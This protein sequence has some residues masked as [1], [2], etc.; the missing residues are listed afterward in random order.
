MDMVYTILDKHILA[1]FL[2]LEVLPAIFNIDLF[3][4]YR[5]QVEEDVAE[6]KWNNK[7]YPW[8]YRVP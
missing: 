4:L 2:I 5:I 7:K 6:S 3:T 8:R 1:C